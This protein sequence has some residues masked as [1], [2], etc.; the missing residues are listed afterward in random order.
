MSTH[1]PPPPDPNAPPPAGPDA[2][3]P[4]GAA[5]SPRGRNVRLSGSP[6]ADAYAAVPDG[7]KRGVVVVHEIFGRQPEIDR[8]VD[9]FAE[10][11][12]A[13]VA[14]DLF[15]TTPKPLCV[16]RAMI[17]TNAGRGPMIAT[18]QRA[19]A[20]L[21]ETAGLPPRSV[22]LIGFCLGGSFALAAGPDWGAVSTNYGGLPP[23]DVMR[24]LPPVIGCYGARDLIFG[25]MGRELESRL[26]RLGVKAEAHTFASV[27]HSF[28]TDGHHPVAAALTRPFFH[29]RY[30]PETAEEAWRLIFAH[31]ERHLETAG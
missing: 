21:G 25:R 11:G 6:P 23:D 8:V 24:G 5:R 12:Y 10:G 20:W 2:P 16:A 19:R 7:A 22:G 4:E 13:A 28:L 30:D 9:R 29:V 17:E 27:G 14:P 3:T 26:P 15:G 1:A 18:L 31:F